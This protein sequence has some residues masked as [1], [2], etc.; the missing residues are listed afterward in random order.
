MKKGD[1][2]IFRTPWDD[3]R[4]LGVL[5]EDVTSKHVH[6]FILSDDLRCPRYSV[7]SADCL[8]LIECKWLRYKN[9]TLI[10]KVTLK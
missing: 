10:D 7:V 9:K 6:I 8:T 2:V 3:S 1:L 4:S 5:V